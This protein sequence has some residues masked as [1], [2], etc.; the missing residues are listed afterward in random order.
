[1][2]TETADHRLAC[3][4]AGGRCGWTEARVTASV[5]KLLV[6]FTCSNIQR[7]TDSTIQPV[8]HKGQRQLPYMALKQ[9]SVGAEQQSGRQ[10]R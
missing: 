2:P 8:L 3:R 6:R 7:D 1:M 4:G 5:L 10:A 9:L